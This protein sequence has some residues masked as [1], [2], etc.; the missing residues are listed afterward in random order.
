MQLDEPVAPVTRQS[1]TTPEW[2]NGREEKTSRVYTHFLESGVYTHTYVELDLY[3]SLHRQ[4]V[5]K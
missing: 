4:A 3:G 5:R 2:K 1:R